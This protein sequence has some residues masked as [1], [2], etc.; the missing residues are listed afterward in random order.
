MSTLP[1]A[2]ANPQGTVSLPPSAEQTE[3]SCMSGGFH[4]A[5]YIPTSGVCQMI[6][7][8]NIESLLFCNRFDA[9]I[10]EIDLN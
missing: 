7:A 5:Y 10:G 9:A 1:V 4:N 8:Q 6:W 2:F 3:N